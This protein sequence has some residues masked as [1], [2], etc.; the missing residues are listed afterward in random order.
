M[1]LFGLQES[2]VEALVW[3]T[4]EAAI[5]SIT[6][7]NGV[8][9]YVNDNFVQ[10]S[11]YERSEL[12]GKTHRLLKSGYHPPSLFRDLWITISQGKIWK[13]D[14]KNRAKNGEFFWL[15]TTITPVRDAQGRI[16]RFVAVRFLMTDQKVLEEKEHN[17][18]DA[19]LNVMED[20]QEAQRLLRQQMR[21]SKKFQSA[22]EAS[23][24]AVVITDPD[25]HIIY[26]NSAWTRLTGYTA[27]EVLGKNPRI[28]KSGSTDPRAYDAL[29]STIHAGKTFATDELLNRRKDGSLYYADISIY[30]IMESGTILYFVGV[31]RDITQRKKEE[32]AKA[33]FV[34]IAS[35]QLRT[36]LTGIRWSI[37]RLK[38]MGKGV[39]PQA[40]LDILDAASGAVRRMSETINALLSL[41]RI[42]SGKMRVVCVPVSLHR[43]LDD[44]FL[45]QQSQYAMAGIA[46]VVECDATCSLDT[47]PVFLREIVTNL[48][49]NACKYTP[50]GGRVRC[51]VTHDAHHVTLTIADTGYGIPVDQ[52]EKVFTKFFRADNIL[53]KVP[54][55]NGLGLY[56]VHS[57][58]T[59]LGGTVTF[60]SQLGKGTTFTVTLPLHFPSH[61]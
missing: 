55:G 16:E 38:K 12:L 57:L 24:D 1:S 43:L 42:E 61:S 27:K 36:P 47:D 48:L 29:W 7:T 35:H 13:G 15:R 60:T 21:E 19:M 51:T 20:M 26:V 11:G 31:Q 46:Y 50:R 39:L 14:I 56:L 5:V 4:K 6:D 8:I 32:R 9:T 52:Q 2:E 25:G 28:L 44:I 3:A 37:G 54:D 22:V 30:P 10:V 23:N 53:S 33:E 59:L 40:L 17:Q 45:T 41:S 58:V 34:S 18:R 49:S